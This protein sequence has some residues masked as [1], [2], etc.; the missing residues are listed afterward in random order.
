VD[1][2][3][4]GPT[5][6]VIASSLGTTDSEHIDRTVTTAGTYSLHVFS[7]ESASNDYLGT[8][9]V[10]PTSGCTATIE[11]PTGQVCAA[12]MCRSGSC[13]S[14]SMCPPLHLCPD[15][16]PGSGAST[17]GARCSTNGDCRSA[18][19]CKWFPEGRACELRGAGANGATCTSFA[20]CGGQRA[21]LD[22]PG[23]YCARAGCV[24]DADCESGTFCASISGV[25]VCSV[26][27]ATD[28][29]RCHA[30]LTCRSVT[31]IS[32]ASRRVCAP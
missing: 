11:C 28:S 31:G 23:G 27:C 18:E 2:E 25:N 26:D 7:L 30:G 24:T 3:L 16:G 10:T 13:T 32:G 21:C 6:T 12:S 1:L 19:A 14:L 17:C 8:V 29:T 5:G 9:M 15:A 20:D 4:V 22:W